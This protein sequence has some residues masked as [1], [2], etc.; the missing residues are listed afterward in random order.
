MEKSD[1]RAT[2]PL[3]HGVK[4]DLVTFAKTMMDL[5]LQEYQEQYIR[6]FEEMT[7]T[8]PDKKAEIITVRTRKQDGPTYYAKT[9][10]R[11]WRYAGSG[12]WE[13]I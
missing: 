9:N 1:G 12:N 3:Q 11:L 7:E 2:S 5:P 13:S 6:F 8:V 4:C 10:D